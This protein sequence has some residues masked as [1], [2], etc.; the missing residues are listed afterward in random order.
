MTSLLLLLNF[1]A[2]IAECGETHQYPNILYKSGVSFVS[3][4]ESSDTCILKADTYWNSGYLH[5]PQGSACRTKEEVLAFNPDYPFGCTE[6]EE[7]QAGNITANDYIQYARSKTSYLLS[8]QLYLPL[9]P[10]IEIFNSYI[11]EKY[12]CLTLKP[13]SESRSVVGNYYQQGGDLFADAN[14]NIVCKKSYMQYYC[15]THKKF[16]FKAMQC[17]GEKLIPEPLEAPC[18]ANP[19]IPGSGE[20]LHTES[21]GTVYNTQQL[22]SLVLQTEVKTG[23]TPQLPSLFTFT[24]DSL[25]NLTKTI[26]VINERLE[27]TSYTKHDANGNQLTGVTP[28]DLAVVQ[29][30]TP[31]GKIATM[32]VGTLVTK[33]TTMRLDRQN[34]RCTQRV[35]RRCTTTAQR[36]S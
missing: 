4:D 14:K 35:K 32:S 25:G 30:F 36:M 9:S 6:Q 7:T 1:T 18:V 15:P 29:T 22:P 12:A 26:N 5:V 3:C 34:K 31:R 19:F 16:D 8:C 24:Y 20:K 17:V 11:E 2:A 10:K 33:H 23:S 21:K 13:D 28:T 27:T